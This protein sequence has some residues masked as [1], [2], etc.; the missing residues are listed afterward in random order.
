MKL[1]QR[2]LTAEIERLRTNATVSS[3][4]DATKLKNFRRSLG[5]VLEK[6]NVEAPIMDQ[7]QLLQVVQKCVDATKRVKELEAEKRTMQRLTESSEA[8]VRGKVTLLTSDNDQLKRKLRDAT[9]HV[10]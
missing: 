6:I 10:I 2:K 3:S 1:E 7:E 8:E 5:N 9:E 4:E